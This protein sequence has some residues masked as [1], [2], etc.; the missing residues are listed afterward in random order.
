MKQCVKL[1]TFLLLLMM[2]VINTSCSS[3]SSAEDMD[4]TTA[5]IEVEDG[6]ALESEELMG[7]EVAEGDMMEGDMAPVEG[8]AE[9]GEAPMIEASP[10]PQSNQQFIGYQDG[11]G[12]VKVSKGDTLMMISYMVYGDYRKWRSLAALNGIEE[13]SELQAGMIIKYRQDMENIPA[14]PA[15]APYMIQNG[16]TLGTIS[17]K[18][19]G[20]T[21]KWKNVWNNNR[22]LIVDP[23]IIFAGFTIYVM[24]E[25]EMAYIEESQVQD[26]VKTLQ[27]AKKN[28]EDDNLMIS[29]N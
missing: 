7:E 20:T 18:H 4:E 15:G 27:S 16:D 17:S 12:Q 25:G 29:L 23:N 5:G 21:K 10:T 14:R 22:Q 9:G 24:P 13:G 11:F 19:Y 2:L 6:E 26:N 28:N 8:V 1:G 3:K